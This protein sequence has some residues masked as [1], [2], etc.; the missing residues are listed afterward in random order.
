MLV[1]NGPDGVPD[2]K[3][4]LTD[5]GR[6]DA[7]A[8]GRWLRAHRPD[9]V[10]CSTAERARETWAVAAAELAM[11]AA[12]VVIA[13]AG[14]AMIVGRGAEAC[15]TTAPILVAKDSARIAWRRKN[16]SRISLRT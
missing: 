14:K 11:T 6:R 8:A 7:T 1:T 2:R 10:V 4:P 5:R 16:S 12:A 3:R 15:G 9:V 13:D